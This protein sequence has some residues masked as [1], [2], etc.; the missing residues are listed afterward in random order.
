[1]HQRPILIIA[2]PYR[3]FFLPTT[4]FTA[5]IALPKAGKWPIYKSFSVALE[6]R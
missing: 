3:I 6:L 4:L 5:P 2:H 1:M